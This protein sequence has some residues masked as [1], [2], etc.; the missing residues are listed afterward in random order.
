M[1][2]DETFNLADVPG[3]TYRSIAGYAAES[4]VVGRALLCGFTIFFKAWRD[5]KY[6]AVI[7]ADGSLYRIEIKGTTKDQDISTTSGGRAGEQIDR[8]VA[9]RE[10]S[11]STDDCDW[12]IATTSRNSFCWIVPVEFIEILNLRKLTIKHISLFK[13]KWNIFNTTDPLIKPFLK[14]GYRSLDHDTLKRIARH[15]E[16]D[17]STLGSTFSFDESNNRLKKYHLN[18]KDRL[19]VA[20]WQKVFEDLID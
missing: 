17:I 15:M 5:S 4:L 12:L 3:G 11:L 16:I 7:D 10:A 20:I 6:D 13:E 2:W 1:N 18:S 14:D 8:A 19:V 9:S